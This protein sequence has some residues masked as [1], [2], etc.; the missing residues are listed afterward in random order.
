[1]ERVKTPAVNGST[2]RTIKSR[3]KDK[4]NQLLKSVKNDKIFVR[5]NKKLSFP[6]WFKIIAYIL[7]YLFMSISLIFIIFRGITFGEEKVTKWIT[8]LMVSFLTSLLLTQPLQVVLIAFFF[9]LVFRKYDDDKDF[10]DDH[11]DDGKS[12]LNDNYKYYEFK[13]VINF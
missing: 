13:N 3:T 6:W 9:V 10:E 5:V 12:S 2:E 7:S 1:L 4:A 11:E 8:S